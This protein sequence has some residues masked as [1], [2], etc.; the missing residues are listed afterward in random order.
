MLSGKRVG[1]RRR[2]RLGR[3]GSRHGGNEVVEA[4]GADRNENRLHGRRRGGAMIE[5][6]A[7]GTAPRA[8]TLPGRKIAE[9]SRLKTRNAWT[10]D[11]IEI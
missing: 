2:T 4:G 11:V 7:A 10:R 8:A 6:M 1:R 5:R 9:G 3:F